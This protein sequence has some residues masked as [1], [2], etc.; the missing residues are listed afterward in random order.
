[1][2]TFYQDDDR[3]YPLDQTEDRQ[4]QYAVAGKGLFG[5]MARAMALRAEYTVSPLPVI[6]PRFVIS[7]GRGGSTQ[8]TRYLEEDPKLVASNI[9]QCMFPYL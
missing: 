5:R 7:A 3:L 1:M 9:L 2:P 4:L 8:I 6:E